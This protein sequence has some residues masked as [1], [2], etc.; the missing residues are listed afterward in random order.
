MTVMASVVLMLGNAAIAPAVTGPASRVVSTATPTKT[1]ATAQVMAVLDQRPGEPTR[2]GLAVMIRGATA[3]SGT[4]ATMAATS[5]RSA[6][7][8]AQAT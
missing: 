4:A 1:E 3:S 2:G 6:R 5:G 7:A 8:T